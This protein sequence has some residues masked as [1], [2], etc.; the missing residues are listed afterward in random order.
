MVELLEPK[1]TIGVCTKNNVSSIKETIDSIVNQEFPRELME[2]I[3]VDGC[4]QD[5]T[6]KV[7]K[8][9]IKNSGIRCRIFLENKGLG[10]ARQIVVNNA[11]GKYIIWVDGD[12]VL[13]KDFVKKQVLFMERNPKVGIAKGKYGIREGKL[14]AMLEDIDFAVSFRREGEINL[15]SLGASG[16][17]YRTEAI[18]RTGGFDRNIPGAGEDTDIE[19][20]IKSA[21]WLL[22]V[23]S[24][25]FYEERRN[26]WRTL[27]KEYYWHGIGAFYVFRKNKRIFSNYKIFP[28]VALLSRLLFIPLAYKL[29]RKKIVVLLPIHYFFKRMAWFAGF[30]C[31]GLK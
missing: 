27:W 3:I 11:Q 17:I 7:I 9:K 4:S 12:M 23:T 31:A 30:V 16:C 19:H 10:F 20:R 5:G 6:L 8:N 15:P 2:L 21:G 25:F 26:T 29:T 14:V 1:V 22:C 13:P 28:L 24:A 18:R